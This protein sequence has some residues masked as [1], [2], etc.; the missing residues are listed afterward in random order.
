MHGHHYGTPRWWVEE[1]IAQ[2]TDILLVIDVQGARAVRAQLERVVGIFL[3]PP[4][5]PELERRLRTR[6]RDPRPQSR[7]AWQT[8]HRAPGD[9]EYDYLVINDDLEC[10]VAEIVAIITA[11]T[12]RIPQVRRPGDGEGAPPRRRCPRRMMHCGAWPLLAAP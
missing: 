4:S 1:Q 6:A 3:A 9:S 8:D 2:G 11:E 7:R 5:L 10:A 12:L